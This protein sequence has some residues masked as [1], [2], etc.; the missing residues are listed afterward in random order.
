VVAGGGGG[1]DIIVLGLLPLAGVPCCERP[2]LPGDST[3][4]S[5]LTRFRFREDRGVV[6]GDAWAR[7]V[8]KGSGADFGS[9]SVLA[10]AVL[11][12]VDLLRDGVRS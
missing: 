10:G 8:F 4:S 1:G 6:D 11:M 12:A 3:L 9:G 7:A 2:A 5:M